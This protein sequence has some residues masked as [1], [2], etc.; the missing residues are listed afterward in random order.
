MQVIGLG[1]QDLP[2]LQIDRALTEQ[3]VGDALQVEIVSIGGL[4]PVGL[5]VEQALPG[6]EVWGLAG[7]R[8]WL[9]L[10]G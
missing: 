6:A 4:L 5:I 3:V 10:H 8:S 1:A 9:I 7:R 2:L